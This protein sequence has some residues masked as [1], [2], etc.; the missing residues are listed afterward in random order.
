M[1]GM[2]QAYKKARKIY[3]KTGRR[4]KFLTFFSLLYSCH[5]RETV[6]IGDGTKL[7]YNGLGCV[8]HDNCIIGRHCIIAQNVTLGGRKFHEGVPRLEDYVEVGAG[9]VILGGVTV[10]EHS[11]I[12]ANAVVLKDVPPYSVA[13]GVP[14]K[15]IRTLRDEKSENG[16]VLGLIYSDLTDKCMIRFMP[17]ALCMEGV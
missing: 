1:L 12:G 2:L 5:L 10:G 11:I 14:A 13:A 15:I 16:G 6:S 8:I 7:G 17:Y 3:L 9:A 4:T